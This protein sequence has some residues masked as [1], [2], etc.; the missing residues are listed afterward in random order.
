[1]SE[2]ISIIVLSCLDTVAMSDE[3]DSNMAT[4]VPLSRVAQRLLDSFWASGK[5]VSTPL[6]ENV[7]IVP[8]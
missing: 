2:C 6:S 8:N 1:M 7:Q 5:K 4:L 3:I